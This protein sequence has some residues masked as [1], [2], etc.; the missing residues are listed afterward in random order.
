MQLFC[1][2]RHYFKG[3]LNKPIY[4]KNAKIEKQFLGNLV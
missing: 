1:Q 2:V 3:W 4:L